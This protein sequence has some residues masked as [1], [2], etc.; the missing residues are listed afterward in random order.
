[1]FRKGL[2]DNC[3]ALDIGVYLTRS[4]ARFRSVMDA[5]SSG[6]VSATTLAASILANVTAVVSFMKMINSTLG[7]LGQL[8]G[9]K[10]LTL[11]VGL[12]LF[13]VGSKFIK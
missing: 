7:W 1:M 4:C 11:Q 6:A 8:V 13:C 5:A 12:C 2:P 10:N 3:D 9:I